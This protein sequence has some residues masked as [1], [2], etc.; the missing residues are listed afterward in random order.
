MTTCAK[1]RST[2][3]TRQKVSAARKNAS[4]LEWA[5]QLKNDAVTRA[6][7]YIE[8]GL[9][10]LWHSVPPQ[11]LPR[12]ITVNRNIGSPVT[13]LD[14]D[15]FGRYPYK[16]DALNDPW[17]I[18]DPTTGQRYPSNDFGA[19]YRS[20]L[21]RHGIFEPQLADRTLLVNTLY[22]DKGPEW[23]VDDGFG[24][25]DEQGNRF[26]FI[27]YYVHWA[28]WSYERTGLVQHGLHSLRDAYLY[29]GEIRYARAGCVLLDRVADVYPSL[30]IS[31][32]DHR[33]YANSHGGTG[34]GKAIGKIWEAVLVQQFLYAYDAFFPAMD[35]PELI[36]FLDGKARQYGLGPKSSGAFIRGNIESGIVKQIFPGQ[37]AGQIHGNNGHHQ[38]ALALAA[39][40]Y[41]T[42]PETQEWIDFVYKPGKLL[43]NPW[44]VTGG[45]LAAIFVN[46]VDRDG[47]GNE[48][49]PGYNNIWL[50]YFMTIADLLDGYDLYPSMNLYENVKFRKMFTSMVPLMLIERYMAKIGDFGA[51]GQP[52]RLLE[53][54]VMLKAFRRYGHPIFAQLAYF[55]NGNKAQGLPLDIFESEPERIEPE[56]AVVI[57]QHGQLRLPSCNL[58]GYGFAVL[59]DGSGDEENEVLRANALRDVWLYYGRNTGHG[60]RDTL[61][62]GICAYGLDLSPDLGYPEV[63]D[64]FA[65]QRHEWMNNTIAH[66]TVVVD[67]SKQHPHIIG[68]PRHFDD[69]GMVKLIDVEAPNVYPQTTMYRRTT[70]MIRVD[71]HH[72]YTVDFFRVKG[73][74]EHHFSFHGAEG[75][76]E[77]EHLRL[78][79]QK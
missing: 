14:I 79:P 66:N 3:F 13:G 12:S 19:Y 39:V 28:L 69:C 36:A 5:I 30:D 72:S 29:T 48:A 65:P 58:A 27:A 64:A 46:D 7:R 75:A 2:V 55:L 9:D 70:A 56:L 40:V 60:H 47:H 78:I 43:S 51:A 38:S 76:V 45:N 16:F 77:T 53:L 71:E 68:Q 41:D 32:Y 21:N 6:D 34:Q 54:R 22:P 74:S 11:S 37:Q 50:H 63:A 15:R 1:T 31:V 18:V 17:K 24:W 57:S 73:G 62:V 33:I 49:S 42:L 20:G 10:Q 61:N 26:T 35:D 52:A 59:R 67:R 44:R 4:E 25:V 8:V 23:G